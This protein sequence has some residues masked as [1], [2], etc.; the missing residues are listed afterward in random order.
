MSPCWP[1]LM[2]KWTQTMQTY[3]PRFRQNA[4]KTAFLTRITSHLS[5]DIRHPS[6][7]RQMLSVAFRPRKRGVHRC[8]T[9]E[10]TTKQ[11]RVFKTKTH[12]NAQQSNHP[13]RL[14]H[15]P[16]NLHKKR[17]FPYLPDRVEMFISGYPTIL[18]GWNF[19][20]TFLKKVDDVGSLSGIPK[21]GLEW[22]KKGLGR[23]RM[24]LGG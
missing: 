15:I 23:F 17:V 6:G 22:R 10:K 18:L 14:F 20:L 5:L 13:N 24:C 3:K 12:K 1:R 16:S 21:C 8:I 19:Y 2:Q 11:I 4:W 7:P 9:M